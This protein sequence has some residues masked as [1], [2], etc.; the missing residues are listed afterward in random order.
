MATTKT[1]AEDA[2]QSPPDWRRWAVLGSA[3]VLVLGGAELGATLVEERLPP[4][5][6]DPPR[7]D[8]K[9]AQL[10]TIESADVVFVGSSMVEVAVEPQL[11][12]DSQ[13]RYSTAYNAA[14][15]NASPRMWQMWLDDVV[16][17]HTN[18]DVVVIGISSFTLNDAGTNR[19]Q[20]ITTYRNSPAFAPTNT[21]DPR[22]WSTL[23]QRRRDLRNPSVWEAVIGE[24]RTDLDIRCVS[25]SSGRRFLGGRFT[26]ICGLSGRD[27]VA[28]QRQPAPPL[29]Y[30][31]RVRNRPYEVPDHYRR[32]TVDGVL[33][34]YTSG[35]RERTALEALVGDLL[36]RQIT[37][38][39][40]IMPAVMD[41]HLPMHPN[42]RIDFDQHLRIA[43]EIAGSAQIPLLLP[44]AVLN[45]S[46][47]FVDPVHLNGTGS[48]LFTAWIA[49]QLDTL[50]ASG[51]LG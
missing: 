6:Y 11:F 7:L 50:A 23:Y 10:E 17:P 9:A 29:G 31:D 12:V 46:R 28:S 26:V 32:R 4:L 30:N 19:D 33:N 14:I 27:C 40:V 5:S 1:P 24:C 22:S 48:D 37:P 20:F 15:E 51:R 8:E 18:P 35:G 36:S 49:E 44:P 38:V 16:I 45:D 41:D 34:D 21:V 3:L 13:A 39:L 2:V 25:G 42:G 43:E 47:Y